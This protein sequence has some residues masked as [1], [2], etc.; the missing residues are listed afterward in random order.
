MKHDVVDPVRIRLWELLLVQLTFAVLLGTSGHLVKRGDDPLEGELW[1]L[2]FLVSLRLA[3][4][5]LLLEDGVLGP[6]ARWNRSGRHALGLMV[7]SDLLRFPMMDWFSRSTYWLIDGAFAS[8]CVGLCIAGLV[9]K[10]PGGRASA[11]TGWGF[12][13]IVLFGLH[14]LPWL[15]LM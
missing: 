14:P 2:L 7:L 15:M 9:Q 10:L 3:V 13:P 12:V 6:R 1:A 11:R 4:V 8:V 5:P